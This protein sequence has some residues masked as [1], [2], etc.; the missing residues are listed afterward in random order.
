MYQRLRPFCRGVSDSIE[1]GRY[2]SVWHRGRSY[3]HPKPGMG[4]VSLLIKALVLR[5]LV[6]CVNHSVKDVSTSV[7]QC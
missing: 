3:D 4:L 2:R 5:H 6:L 7:L 1:L